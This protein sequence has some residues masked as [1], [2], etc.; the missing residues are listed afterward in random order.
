MIDRLEHYIT[1][2]ILFV[3]GTCFLFTTQQGQQVAEVLE[4]VPQLA[5]KTLPAIR[6]SEHSFRDTHCRI[7]TSMANRIWI[8]GWFGLGYM[9]RPRNIAKT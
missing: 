8:S 6:S 4:L 7:R 2:W 1:S 5:W 3:A 9:Y